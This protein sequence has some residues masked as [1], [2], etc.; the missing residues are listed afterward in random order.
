MQK[1]SRSSGLRLVMSVAGAARHTCTS[2]D[3]A[4]DAAADGDWAADLVPT[5][6][7]ARDLDRLLDRFRDEVR[8]AARDRGVTAAQ[9]AEARGHLEAA[10][11]RLG[12][13]FGARS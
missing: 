9:V 2:G 8:D 6:D 1:T 11:G 12:T 4:A 13:A 3:A 5:G 10:C 7:P